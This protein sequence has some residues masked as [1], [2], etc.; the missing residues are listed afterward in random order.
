MPA[1]GNR[2]TEVEE[3]QRELAERMVSKFPNR[4]Y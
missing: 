1:P 2:G 4:N 3:L